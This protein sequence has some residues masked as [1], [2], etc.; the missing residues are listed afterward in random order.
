MSD[1][2]LVEIAI[3]IAF[4][5]LLWSIGKLISPKKPNKDKLQPFTGGELPGKFGDL[6]LF[7]D[8]M[9]YVILFLIL[10]I[11]IFVMAVPFENRLLP[12]IYSGL[13]LLGVLLT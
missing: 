10:D 2:V 12:G 3:T 4:P 5:I 8:T 1:L 7:P 13:V 9:K 6:Y 11:F